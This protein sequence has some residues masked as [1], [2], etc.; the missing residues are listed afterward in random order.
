MGGAGCMPAPSLSTTA[1]WL[2]PVWGEAEVVRMPKILG[3]YGSP[4]KG[5][6]SDLL[7]DRALGGA[8]SEGGEINLECKAVTYRFLSDEEKKAAAAKRKKGKG[9]GSKKKKGGH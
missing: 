4:R 9:K 1:S 3:I 5:G 8:E 7:L 6:N 2:F